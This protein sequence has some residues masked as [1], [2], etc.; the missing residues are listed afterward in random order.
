MATEGFR[1]HTLRLY[2]NVR[3]CTRAHTECHMTQKPKEVKRR[4]K[5]HKAKI[6]PIIA[7]KAFDILEFCEAYR[8]GRSTAY[9][10]IR[11]GRLKI[12]KVGKLTRIGVEAAENWRRQREKAATLGPPPVRRTEKLAEAGVGT[13]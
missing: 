7:R 6:Q 4:A 1:Q 11:E 9:D 5:K 12:F 3:A 10:E 8:V 2:L 13:N